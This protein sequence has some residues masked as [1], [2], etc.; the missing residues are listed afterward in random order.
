MNV[1]SATSWSWRA[2]RGHSVTFAGLFASAVLGLSIL[3]G[4]HHLLSRIGAPWYVLLLAPM[5]AVG[6]LAKKEQQWIPEPARRRRLARTLFWGS[7][8]LAFA[9]AWLRPAPPTASPGVP[10]PRGSVRK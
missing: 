5:F 9:I 7:L 1:I 4:F 3:S 2:L 6:W 8:A 10:P